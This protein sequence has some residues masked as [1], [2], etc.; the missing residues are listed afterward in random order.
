MSGP[1]NPQPSPSSTAASMIVCIVAPTST[2]QNGTGQSISEPS[3]LIL[4]GSW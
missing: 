3:S 1:M 2:H 4:S